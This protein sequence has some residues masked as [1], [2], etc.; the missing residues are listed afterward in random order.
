MRAARRPAAEIAALVVVLVLGALLAL[1]GSRSGW[2]YDEGTY[3]LSVFDL[4][5]GQALG[6]DVYAPQPP[7][8][9][10]LVR[11]AAWMFGHD[12]ADV[13]KGIIVVFLLGVTGA[14][15]LARAL[16]GPWAGL[17]AAAFVVVAPP[18][19]LE[20]A[21]V[22]ADLPA[23]ALTLLA[24]GLAAQ[25]PGN[26]RTQLLLAFSAGAL[27]MMAVGVK[28]TALIGVVPLVL[29]LIRSARP[30]ARVTVAAVGAFI[31]LAVVLL[32]YRH[33]IGALWS[34]LVEY[35]Q[36]AR[37]TPNLV[38]R[39]EILGI[40]LDLHSAF[41]IA[42]LAGG[43][44]AA[45]RVIRKRSLATAPILVPVVVLALLGFLALA[46]YRPL[47]EN[48]LVLA[49][50]VLAV[51]AAVLIGWGGAP[52]SVRGQAILASFIV[53]LALAAF[54]Q[55]WRRVG[56][57]LEAASPD[58][59]GLAGRLAYRTPVTAFV[60][61]DNPGI[62]YLARRRTPGAL[63]DTARLR[64]DTGTLTDA[65]V[66]RSIDESCVV[67]VVAARAFLL[68]PPLLEAFGKRFASV[69]AS[70]AGQLY[71]GRRTP[72]PRGC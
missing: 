72:L 54:S 33:A 55:G 47:H 50:A 58:A 29:L 62:A 68:R 15:L 30:A 44:L 31:T 49:S 14:Y 39:R 23:L 65:A 45:W 63:V 66:L 42:V 32:V 43:A 7:L 52:L 2:T 70:R 22:H 28:L 12:I 60:V 16:V 35:R 40:V 8:F 17:A 69:E 5:G 24:L 37:R 61:S 41:T 13:R 3:L 57:E 64:F 38:S 67:A 71:F 1:R 19:P 36:A 56:V 59:I 10:S 11:L 9:Y 20:V 46:T 4:E 21:R 51:L 27:L 48:H 34:S 25:T 18:I 53:V 26:R 6:T